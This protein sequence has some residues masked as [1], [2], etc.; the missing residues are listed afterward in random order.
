MGTWLA[1]VTMLID[2]TKLTPTDACLARF[3][4]TAPFYVPG[5]GWQIQPSDIVVLVCKSKTNPGPPEWLLIRT[6]EVSDGIVTGVTIGKLSRSNVL[7]D[8]MVQ[9]PARYVVASVFGN[10]R[11]A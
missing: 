7:E 3:D 11:P 9:F 6:S 2:S 4:E 5:E 1:S 8:T 10:K